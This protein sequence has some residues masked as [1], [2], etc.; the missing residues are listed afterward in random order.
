M[1]TKCKVCVVTGSRSDYGLLRPVM[2]EISKSLDLELQIIAT[3]AHLSSKFGFT[4]RE[5]EAD[6]FLVDR[7]IE[8]LSRSDSAVGVAN[9]MSLCLIGM[10]NAFE[11]LKPDII[12]VLG[13]RY[14]I[15]ATAQ[16]AMLCRI[17]LA[18]MCGGDVASGTYDNIIRHCITKISA[19]HFT[20]HDEA[21]K[22]VIQLGE[23][24]D[25]VFCFGSTCVDNIK[26]LS[27][28]NKDFLRSELNVNLQDKLYVVT[29]HPLTMGESGGVEELH[30]LLDALA[31]EL[32]SDNLTVVFTKANAD[33]GGREINNILE[34]FVN[35]TKN[36]FIFESLGARMYL[37]LVKEA[38]LVIGNSSSGIYEAPYLMTVTVD[39]GERQHQRKAPKSVFRCV[40]TKDSIS[41]AISEALKFEFQIPEMIYG[42]GDTSRRIVE[43]LRTARDETTLSAKRFVDVNFNS[44][45]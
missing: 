13:D 35:K 7:K 38:D 14:E 17:P 3:G 43:V 22:R 18:H 15:L 5:I 20:T 30:N 34:N 44:Q 2:E 36:T 19:L 42:S 4:F 8:I 6:G 26:S 1:N 25:R 32:V 28:L 37:S 31:E 39:I 41:N 9:A 23:D 40:G 29:Y 21:L 45:A 33:N 11:E 16:A 27:L 24:P 12:L 10:A